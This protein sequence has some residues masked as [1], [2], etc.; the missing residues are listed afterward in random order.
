VPPMLIIAPFVPCMQL[1]PHLHSATKIIT[2]Q[3]VW[4]INIMASVILHPCALKGTHISRQVHGGSTLVSSYRLA[5]IMFC[6]LTDVH[7][8]RIVKGTAS[9]MCA[10]VSVLIAGRGGSVDAL[11]VQV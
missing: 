2:G 4:H 8:A 9:I 11:S 6:A 3:G 5:L 10:S 7:L 1:V